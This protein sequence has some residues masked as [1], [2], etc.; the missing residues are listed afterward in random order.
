[1]APKIAI[2]YYSMYG[3]IRQ[4]AEAEKKGAEAAG[5]QVDIYQIPETLPDEVLAKMH[6]PAKPTDIPFLED[7]ATLTQY[8]GFLFG[9]PTRYGNFPA[10]WKTF[11]DKT[12]AIWASGGYW[13]KKAGLF[14]STGTPGGG[15]ESTAIAAMSTLAH[16]GIIYVPLGYAKTF[17][18]ITNLDEVHGGSPWGAGTYAGPTGARQPTALELKIATT[19][20][21]AFAQALSG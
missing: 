11:W 10:Q 18:D 5:A 7:P 19:Q 3:H 16:H 8:D 6:A 1:M 21:E 20:G 9:I 17:P 2:V 14:I 4:L 13:G 15:Q 12:G